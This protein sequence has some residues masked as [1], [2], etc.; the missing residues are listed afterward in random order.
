MDVDTVNSIRYIAGRIAPLEP[1]KAFVDDEGIYIPCASN[2]K[3]H[4]CLITKELFVEA[5][6]KWIKGEEHEPN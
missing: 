2:P 4:T 5:Y 3:Y 1:V 6:N